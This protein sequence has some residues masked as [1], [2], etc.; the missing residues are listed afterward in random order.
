MTWWLGE[1]FLTTKLKKNE[2]ESNE[3]HLCCHGWTPP[4]V[5]SCTL[6]FK[7]CW[8]CNYGSVQC[9]GALAL[10]FIKLQLR[11]IHY[12][13]QHIHIFILLSLGFQQFGCRTKVQMSFHT[14]RS[15]LAKS[16]MSKNWFS[17]VNCWKWIN[18]HVWSVKIPAAGC[19][20]LLLQ[21]VI[22]IL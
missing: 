17:T 20:G 8:Y 6:I 4:T 2:C 11:E 9:H 3:E 7:H 21:L 19:K 10:N 13:I 1:V 16:E 5:L 12:N 18:S 22:L 14:W 15:V